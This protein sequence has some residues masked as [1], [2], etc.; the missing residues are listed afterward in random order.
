MNIKIEKCNGSTHI[1]VH[2]VNTSI[3]DWFQTQI[4]TKIKTMT[5][6][7]PLILWCHNQPDQQGAF[8]LQVRFGLHTQYFYMPEI[9]KSD[10]LA[11]INNSLTT[12]LVGVPEQIRRW[13]AA[14]CAEDHSIGLEV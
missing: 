4:E 7:S 11:I 3:R 12:R 10:P 13:I 14:I 1:A 5:T 6:E 2:P 8:L 9:D